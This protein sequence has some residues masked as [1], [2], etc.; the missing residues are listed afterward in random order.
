ML[1]DRLR[2]RLVAYLLASLAPMLIGAHDLGSDFGY[3]VLAT[4][5]RERAQLGV[6]PLRWSPALA[7]SAQTWA[8]HLA[9]TGKFEHAPDDPTSPKGENLWA[10][11]RGRFTPEAMTGAWIGEKQHFRSGTFPN[12]SKTGRVED[13][14]HYTQLVWRDTREVGCALAAG[15]QEDILVCRYA[16]PGNYMGERPF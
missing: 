7:A 15:E 8:E 4:H 6:P 5:N 3:R 9:A 13:V 14:A 1:Q 2:A 11:S 10:G 16:N 12:N